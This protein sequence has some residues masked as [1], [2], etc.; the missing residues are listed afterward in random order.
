MSEDTKDE[1]FRQA[2]IERC[3]H[4]Y[5]PY[6]PIH[7]DDIPDMVGRV[8]SFD[9]GLAAKYGPEEAIMISH[10]QFWISFNRAKGIHF[11]EGRYWT[12]QSRKD[13]HIQFPYWTEKEVRHLCDSLVSK[14][15]LMKGNF[16]KNPLNRTV[17][18]AFVNEK[19]FKVDG[20]SSNNLYERQ[21]G[22]IAKIISKPE[23]DNTNSKNVSDWPKRATA[24]AKNG[25]CYKDTDTI[26]T[27]KKEEYMSA[28][29]A[30]VRLA[31]FFFDSLREINPKQKKPNLDKWAKDF[32]RIMRVDGRTEDELMA[33]IKHMIH[34]HQ[35]N[36]NGFSWFAFVQSP[37]KIREKYDK[38]FVDM[39][40]K[41]A[42]F[43][44]PTE[45]DQAFLSKVKVKYGKIKGL[46]IGNDYIEFDNG[47][48]AVHCKCGEKDFKMK[49]LDQLI[50][51]KLPIEGL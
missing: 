23:K 45:N 5:N 46:L 9:I 38:L 32:D 35:T 30:S 48:T 29:P 28:P 41:P 24:L 33:A 2:T 3:P 21:K 51:R 27:D 44:R 16:S 42:S 11:H 43:K 37:D 47:M 6:R 4:D 25:H 8:H 50:K 10:F 19:K 36:T 14:G 20:E 31:T 34:V 49:V 12:Y 40:A 39:Q 22:P 7:E 13:L 17:W 18:F 26:H 15:V 1:D